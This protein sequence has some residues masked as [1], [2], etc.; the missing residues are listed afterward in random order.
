MASILR[1]S[2]ANEGSTWVVISCPGDAH[3]GAFSEISD[4]CDAI[5]KAN[6]DAGRPYA[7][8]FFKPVQGVEG[9]AP[10]GR[11]KWKVLW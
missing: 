11:E 8:C 1:E 4:L 3:G 10:D 2:A 6:Y 7:C 5:N 9:V